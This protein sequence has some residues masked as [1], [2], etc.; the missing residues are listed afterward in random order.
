MRKDERK[1]S[2]FVDLHRHNKHHKL[3]LLN[4]QLMET[5]DISIYLAFWCSGLFYIN[6]GQSGKVGA[7]GSRGRFS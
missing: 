4:Q 5:A 2:G 7:G 1:G 6:H 3:A